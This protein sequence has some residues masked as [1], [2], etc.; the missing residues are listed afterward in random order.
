MFFVLSLVYANKVIYK[1]VQIWPELICTN[2]HTNQFRSYLN[3]LVI[4]L[5][6]TPQKYLCKRQSNPIAGLDRPWGFQEAEDPR[7][8]DNRYMEVVRLSTLRTD[9]LYPQE[10]FL[11]LISVRGWVNPRTIVR[12]EGL[13]QWRISLTPL[14]IEPATF[15]LVAQCLNQLRYSVLYVY[16]CGKLKW[17]ISYT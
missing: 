16:R 6:F 12:P 7:F 17:H 5:V 9:H 8:Q 1:V 2:V 4:C 11:V 14:G 15:R 10:L 3:H 13:C